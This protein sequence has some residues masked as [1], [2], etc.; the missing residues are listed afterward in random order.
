VIPVLSREQMR[1]FDRHAIEACRVAGVLLMENAGRNAAGV[2]LRWLGDTRARVLIVAGTGNNGGDGFVVARRL[3]ATGHAAEVYVVGDPTKIAGD[4]RT[5]HD[6][7]R[8]LGGRVLAVTD[9]DAETSLVQALAALTASDVVVDALLGTGLDRDVDGTRARIIE[10]MNA[11]PARRLALDVPSGLCAN[12]GAVLGLAVRA[13]ATVTFGHLKLGL[14]TPTGAEHSG[15]VHVV[16]IGVPGDLFREVECSAL[17]FETDDAAELLA[18]RGVAAHKGSAGHVVAVAGSAGK[19]GAAL[20]VARGALRAGAGLCTICTFPDAADA[21]D[22]RVLEEMTARI[23]GSRVEESLDAALDRAD[24]VVVGPGLGL[25]ELSRRA[26]EHVVLHWDGTK[27]VDADALTVFA[28]RAAEL[29]RARG[30]LILT[31][32]PGE[33]GRLLG[34]SAGEVERDRF[35]ALARI[36]ELTHSVVLLKGART[37]VGAPDELPLVTSAGSPALATAGAGDVLAGVVGALAVH[38]EPRLAA[39]LGAHLHALSAERWSERTGADR[40]LLAHEVADGIPAVLARLAGGS[41]P[42]PD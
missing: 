40:G 9:D 10:A 23:D 6:A 14:L 3:L 17:L 15:D 36:V 12:T 24:V 37:L 7:W 25:D 42:M 20:L 8:G 29:G 32:H 26:A 22:R 31:P 39:M 34:T 21:L 28:G 41:P 18:P 11:S 35:S 19:T 13:D 5:N 30:R 2:L 1:D 27:I 33:L 4:A 16:D 38:T